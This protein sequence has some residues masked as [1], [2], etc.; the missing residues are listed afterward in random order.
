MSTAHSNTQ[1]ASLLNTRGSK[2]SRGAKSSSLEDASELKALHSKYSGSVKAL[3]ELFPDWT[4]DDLLSAF[5]DA[6]G[7][8]EGTINNITEGHATQWGEVKSR[9]EKRQA[10]KQPKP[11]HHREETRPLEKG[12]NVPRPASLR[13]GVRGGAARG[14]RSGQLHATG[15]RGKPAPAAKPPAPASTSNVDSSA[16]WD[17]GS[18]S[19]STT[20]DGWS[21]EASKPR[22][23]A[24]NAAPA[25]SGTAVNGTASTAKPAGMSWASIA[26]RG[27]KQEP[28][29]PPKQA[30][31]SEDATGW[32]IDAED[33]RPEEEE[34]TTTSAAE[35]ASEAADHADNGET[36]VETVVEETVADDGSVLKT[37]ETTVSQVARGG[38][39][40]ADQQPSVLSVESALKDTIAEEPQAAISLPRKHVSS[41]RRLKQDAPVVMP[42]GNSAVERI[43]VQFG[44]LS[45]G[46]VELGSLKGAG[47]STTTDKLASESLAPQP[48]AKEPVQPVASLS[49]APKTEAAAPAPVSAPAFAQPTPAQA[50][51]ADTTTSQ[52]PLTTYLQQQ[53]Q[54]QQHASTQAQS[55]PNANAISQMP[56]PN[57]YGAAALY[58]AEVQRNMM[59]FYDNYGYGQFVANKDAANAGS[60]AADSQT[61]AAG[62]SQTA[63]AN[64]S[65]NLSQAGPFPQQI[66]QPFGMNHG[67]PYY[68]PYYYSMMQHGSQYHNP[69][70]GNNPALAAAYSQ[71]FMKQ[72]SMYPMYLGGTP[73]GPQT[74][75]SQ[76]PQQPSQQ[77][78]QQPQT[79][80]PSQ[81][82]PQG[83]PHPQ[84]QQQPQQVG[85]QQA[86]VNGTG[87][88]ANAAYGNINAQK[89]ANPYGH[90]SSNIGSGFAMYDQDSAGLSNSPQQF[91]LGGIPGILSASKGGS[92]DASA[93]GMH[94]AGTA[95]VIGGT[96]YYSAP[97]H[98]HQQQQIG[99]YPS[100]A[101]N[102]HPQGYSHHQQAYYNPYAPNYNQTQAPHVYQQQ[103]QQ[104]HPAAQTGHQQQSKQYWEK[105]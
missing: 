57:D 55:H 53:Q 9:K 7:D 28:V 2:A 71:P 32:S 31:L 20:A 59:G 85:A 33:I 61:P 73:Q 94:P 12:N 65:S 34:A 26:K 38:V 69:A 88:P 45:I 54:Q 99:S 39:D 56:L 105:Q 63:S 100:Q 77:A 103:Q 44:S 3:K 58:G 102:T 23:Q 82:Q 18:V 80:V 5:K 75:S 76:Q 89:P 14:A 101:S 98:Q 25:P 67:M 83:V 104:Q 51:A 52:G 24:T 37:E 15:S 68:N 8:L 66:P 70:F 64:G 41:T 21:A 79:G 43:G 96:T 11:K 90:Y 86:G 35:L 1:Q 49:A 81:Q 87:V 84:Q 50:A 95:P 40:A 48:E 13:G 72:Q 36:V 16:G 91:G 78:S 74:A 60:S 27:V 97:Q 47:A 6:E 10:V 29:E 46:G 4:E 42:S 17:L 62:G 30:E 92:K 93:K 19:G 22:D